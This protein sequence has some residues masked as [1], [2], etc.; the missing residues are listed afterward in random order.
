MSTIIAGTFDNI[1]Q[2]DIAR[3][4]L[5]AVYGAAAV[6]VFH[7]NPAGQHDITPIGGDS[8][9]DAG[10]KDAHQETLKGAAVGGVVGLGLGGI[11]AGLV[12]AAAGPVIGALA[13]VTATAVGAYTGSLVG[14]LE[15]LDGHATQAFSGRTAGILV[16]VSADGDASQHALRDLFLRAGAREVEIAHGSITDGEW[17]DFDPMREPVYLARRGEYDGAGRRVPEV[18]HG[19]PPNTAPY[20]HANRSN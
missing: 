14:T 17:P 18:L 9:A 11:G 15:G 10:A 6:A 13:I 3:A 5:L 2:A 16:G 4:E 12:A 19:Q 8:I 7:L 1:A 20:E